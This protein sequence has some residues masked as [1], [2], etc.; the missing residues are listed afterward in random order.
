MPGVVVDTHAILWYL[1]GDMRLSATALEVLDATTAAGEPIYVPA[2][3]LIELSYLIEKGR[4]P[5]EVRER[6]LKALD[7]A[8]SACCLPPLDRRVADAMEFVPRGEV[9]D[10]PDRIIAATPVALLAPLI[11]RDGRIRSSRVQTIW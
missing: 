5:G 9:P 7:D 3:T 2:I 8:E 1:A 11:S 10:L 4:L 6:L